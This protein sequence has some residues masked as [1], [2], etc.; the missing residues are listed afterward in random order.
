MKQKDLLTYT[1][2]C[3]DPAPPG[4]T[5]ERA[6]I[7]LKSGDRVRFLVETA[8]TPG[9]HTLMQVGDKFYLAVIREAHGEDVRFDF[10][11]EFTSLD[12]AKLA[13]EAAQNTKN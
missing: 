7:E 6:K 11:Q 1:T 5:P 3:I 12:E 4:W 10:V 8:L 13:L 9:E 2:P